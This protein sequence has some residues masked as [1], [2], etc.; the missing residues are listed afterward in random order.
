MLALIEKKKWEFVLL[1]EIRAESRG[2]LW[3]REE[4]R[5]MAVVYFGRTAVVLRGKMMERW[6]AE[7]QRRRSYL[8]RT[9]TVLIGKT[10][11]HSSISAFMERRQRRN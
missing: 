1:S 2:V 3:L 10:A 11:V 4:E 7:R 5:E 9:T 6:R 8:K